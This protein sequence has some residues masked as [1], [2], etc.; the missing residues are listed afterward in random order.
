VAVCSEAATDFHPRH[1]R[2]HA[3][4]AGA[5]LPLSCVSPGTAPHG[6]AAAG[7]SP[8]FHAWVF[9]DAGLPLLRASLGA[10]P[11]GVATTDTP[12]LSRCGY[13]PMRASHHCGRVL[14][15]LHAVCVVV[16]TLSTSLYRGMDTCRCAPPTVAGE[17][18]N[19][20]ARCGGG[21]HPHS[22]RHG[23]LSVPVSHH[24]GQVR[25]RLHAVWRRSE[26]PPSVLR[27]G[28][29]EHCQRFWAKVQLRL[30]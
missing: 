12:T 14:E 2:P 7:T 24:R 29:W 5:H 17:S 22:S 1:L 23:R 16:G 3:A 15:W 27:V 8:S 10:A 21:W 6:V 4:L 19:G 26:P 28:Q 11:R 9:A 18:K 13:L 25:E 30:V 20:S